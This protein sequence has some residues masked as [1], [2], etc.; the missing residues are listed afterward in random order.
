MLTFHLDDNRVY[1]FSYQQPHPP[2][3]YLRCVKCLIFH[4][5][6]FGPPKIGPMSLNSNSTEISVQCTYPPSFI[7]LCLIVRKLL[8]SQTY[9]QTK[10][11]GQKR[12]PRLRC[13]MP[14]L[15]NH[16]NS[17]IWCYFSSNNRLKIALLV[18]TTQPMS[19]Q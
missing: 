19:Q 3:L 12:P 15:S 7:T 6:G 16:L 13:A 4:I 9:K 1:L 17:Y 8:C 10:T 14:V 2:M 18:T 11:F 5:M